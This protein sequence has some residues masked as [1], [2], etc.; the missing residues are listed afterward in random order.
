MRAVIGSFGQRVRM[1]RGRIAVRNRSRIGVAYVFVHALL[2]ARDAW[3]VQLRFLCSAWSNNA[4]IVKLGCQ[5]S[6][7]DEDWRKLI[8]CHRLPRTMDL[9][10]LAW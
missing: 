9:R 3:E 6:V 2:R 7:V 10:F 4:A 5:A 1:P 8:A